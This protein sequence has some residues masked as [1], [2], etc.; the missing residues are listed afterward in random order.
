MSRKY[1]VYAVLAL[2]TV[3]LTS[4]CSTVPKKLREEVSGIRSRVDT[5]EGRVGS[6][7]SRQTEADRMVNQQ[8]QVIEEIKVAR[9][10][11]VVTNVMIK[12][13]AIKSV[14][15]VKDIQTYL[16]NAGF[17]KGAVDGIKGRGTNRAIKEFQ[18]ANG[19]K[20]DGVVGSQTWEA[21]SKYSSASAEAPIG[22]SEGETK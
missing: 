22:I 1:L 14:P 7:E 8:S 13:R 18:Q 17:Y 4:G 11:P 9:E 21:L 19:L 6:V 10:R 15:R 20:V 12:E 5:L 2:S 16:K 3:F